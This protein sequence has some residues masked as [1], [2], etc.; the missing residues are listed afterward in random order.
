MTT[1]IPIPERALTGESATM[2]AEWAHDN[3]N[4]EQN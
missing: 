4:H 3:A 2:I 1:I